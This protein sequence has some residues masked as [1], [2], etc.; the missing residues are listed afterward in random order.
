MLLCTV[1]SA[2]AKEKAPIIVKAAEGVS[3]TKLVISKYSEDPANSP[4][5]TKHENGI[6]EID[7]E[8]D[9]IESY[10]IIDWT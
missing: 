2:L 6:Y 7:I 10:E 9:L 3:A 1:T 4:H 8:T 5:R